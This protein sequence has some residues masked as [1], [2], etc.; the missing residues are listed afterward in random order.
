MITF[1]LSEYNLSHA[2]LFAWATESGADVYAVASHG[3]SDPRTSY[4]MEEK[5]MV[6]FKL[7]FTKYNPPIITY[8]SKIT[9]DKRY[10]Y[11]PYIP[12]LKL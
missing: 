1:H 8:K 2:D 11:C 7:I 4:M 10:Y 6:V 3:S 5:D 12:K 9:T